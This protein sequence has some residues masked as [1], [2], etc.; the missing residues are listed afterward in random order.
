MMYIISL[1][2]IVE[3][4]RLEIC[5]SSVMTTSCLM[6]SSCLNG[7][8]QV[9][10]DSLECCSCSEDAKAESDTAVSLFFLRFS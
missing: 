9:I 10:G 8:K 4:K 6:T 1:D 5:S 2:Y 3:L 7:N